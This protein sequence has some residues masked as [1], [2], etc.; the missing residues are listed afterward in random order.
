M[1]LETWINWLINHETFIREWLIVAV[2]LFLGIVA[3]LQV[4]ASNRQISEARI[5]ERIETHSE[6]LKNLYI[7]WYTNL[8]EIP[9][10]GSIIY[11]TRLFSI[12]VSCVE[13]KG[14]FSDLEYHLPGKYA[15]LMEKWE[16]FKE[17]CQQYYQK[18]QEIIENIP[19]LTSM[20]R[21]KSSFNLPPEALYLKAIELLTGN[22]YYEYVESTQETRQL[23][24]LIYQKDNY[25]YPLCQLVKKEEMN[26]IKIQFEKISEIIKKEYEK[27][28]MNLI[29]IQKELKEK[30]EE[31]KDSLNKLPNYPEYDNMDCEYIFPKTER[32]TKK[33]SKL[34]HKK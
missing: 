9:H 11:R 26:D 31:I 5:K 16:Y 29:N 21:N 25:H 33:L 27:D 22:K 3:Y 7:M 1:S 30:H 4:K 10:T 17:L 20:D 12:A 13:Q 28:I 15:G 32:W 2:T 18:Q 8:P 6:A 24:E 19:V 34:F 14:L 23:Y